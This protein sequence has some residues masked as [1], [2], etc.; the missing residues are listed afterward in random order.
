MIA[1]TKAKRKR[2]CT[3]KMTKMFEY[4]KIKRIKFYIYQTFKH[5]SNLYLFDYWLYPVKG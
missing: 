2:L 3:G 1:D 4:C 5:L